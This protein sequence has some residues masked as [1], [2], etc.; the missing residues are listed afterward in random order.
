[1][2]LL[3]D[4]E[5]M[6]HDSLHD[7]LKL[8]FDQTRVYLKNNPNPIIK[9]I[10]LVCGHRSQREQSL[11]FKNGFSK[12]QWPHG[13]HNFYPSNA[14]DTAPLTTDKVAINWNNIKA[15]REMNKIMMLVAR[16]LD[17][18]IRFGADF[19]MDG[20]LTNDRF[21]DMPHCERAEK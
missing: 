8:L 7:D 5:L 20:D 3:T 17:L 1:M 16:N 4:V 14:L 11:A 15:F 12:V 21:V 13:A 9:D 19:D 18:K 10:F 2:R 6:R